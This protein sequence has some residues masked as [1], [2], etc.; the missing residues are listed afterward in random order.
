MLP[1]VRTKI[2][3]DQVLNTAS[4]LRDQSC[5]SSDRHEF[6]G[7]SFTALHLRMTHAG[8]LNISYENIPVE[9]M[10]YVKNILPETPIAT[11]SDS[12]DGDGAGRFKPP[13][14]PLLTSSRLPLILLW[15]SPFL[16]C[17]PPHATPHAYALQPRRANHSRSPSQVSPRSH[18]LL[19]GGHEPKRSKVAASLAWD[20]HWMK[21]DLVS[22]WCP[23]GFVC[24]AARLVSSMHGAFNSGGVFH[25]TAI[26]SLS[27]VFLTW[28]AHAL[29]NNHS[30]RHTCPKASWVLVLPRCGKSP[31]H[32]G[33]GRQMRDCTPGRLLGAFLE[34]LRHHLTRRG[35]ADNGEAAMRMLQLWVPLQTPPTASLR[36]LPL[37]SVLHS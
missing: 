19:C 33:V 27:V 8:Q 24:L 36:A 16:G 32:G 13:P 11:W 17:S 29:I 10:R 21:V 12:E 18:L 23:S 15:I 20:C 3:W 34:G 2:H 1:A 31:L 4:S 37:A 6:F 30:L 35:T 28:R 14:P 9:T 26:F 22:T 7:T 25:P 5:A